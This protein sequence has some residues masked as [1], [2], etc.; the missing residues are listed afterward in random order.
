MWVPCRNKLSQGSAR[1]FVTLSCTGLCTVSR[2]RVLTAHM[3]FEVQ[4]VPPCPEG[5]HCP[6][7]LLSLPGKSVEFLLRTILFSFKLI[8][9]CTLPGA[10]MPNIIFKTWKI[11]VWHSHFVVL[12]WLIASRSRSR[13]WDNSENPVW[14]NSG[15]HGSAECTSM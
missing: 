3:G 7:F 8:W 12:F 4:N 11:F 15:H 14:N 6:Q 13:R 10:Q 1:P 9:F 5:E 2:I